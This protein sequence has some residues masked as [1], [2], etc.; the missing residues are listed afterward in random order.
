MK[1][2]DDFVKHTIKQMHYLQK[3]GISREDYLKMPF[4][5]IKERINIIT[6]E[7]EKKNKS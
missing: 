1:L 4:W 3:F 7:I 2:G 6:E 5:E